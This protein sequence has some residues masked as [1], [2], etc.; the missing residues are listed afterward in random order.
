MATI[1][2]Y[3]EHFE[4]LEKSLPPLDRKKCINIHGINDKKRNQNDDIFIQ[5]SQPLKKQQLPQ[6][7]KKQQLPQSLKKSLKLP[8]I[9]N[10][11]PNQYD[12]TPEQLTPESPE[13]LPEFKV[14]EYIPYD[15]NQKK[16]EMILKF[17]IRY[18]L[19]TE[20]ETIFNILKDKSSTDIKF[21]LD[22]LAD[23]YGNILNYKNLLT[24]WVRIL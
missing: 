4:H 12:S 23:D 21:I 20:N 1:N 9:Y 19:Y 10:T 5:S 17:T 13:L 3:L 15:E 2:P 6:S 18:N 24:E 7:L 11:P 22:L 14:K 16:K 8:H